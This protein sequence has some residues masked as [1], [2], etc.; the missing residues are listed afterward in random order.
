VASQFA[1]PN[2]PLRYAMYG[3]GGVETAAWGPGLTFAPQGFR[4]LDARLGGEPGRP[5]NMQTR[6]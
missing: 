3:G 4:P 6:R 5:G 1:S 2:M